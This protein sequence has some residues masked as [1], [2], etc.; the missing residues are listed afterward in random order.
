MTLKELMDRILLVC[1][2][3]V[4][5]EDDRG[6]VIVYT[7][8]TVPRDADWESGHGTLEPLDAKV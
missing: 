6:E 4:F 8:Q 3:A 7:G 5:D 1:P 2:Q